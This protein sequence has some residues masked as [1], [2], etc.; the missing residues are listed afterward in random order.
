[1]SDS[2]TVAV[3]GAG[4]VGTSCALWL[5]IKGHSVILIDPEKPG[6]GTSSGNACTI[7]DYGC[8]PVNNPTIFK[9]LPSLMFSRN[10]PLSVDPGYAFSHLPWLLKFL[11]NCRRA[12]VAGRLRR[13]HSLRSRGHEQRREAKRA[14]AEADLDIGEL[15]VIEKAAVGRLL[16]NEQRDP[17]QGDKPKQ[18][19]GEDPPIVCAWPEHRVSDLA[20]RSLIGEAGQPR[21][22]RFRFA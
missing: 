5:Q 13:D 8:V 11:A 17:G 9:R 12:R 1:M 7:A 14:P 22:I 4:I 3:I 10:S 15:F 19:D 18:D 20:S 21:S 6:S 2:K 16:P